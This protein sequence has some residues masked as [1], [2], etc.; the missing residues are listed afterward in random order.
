MPSSLLSKL[1]LSVFPGFGRTVSGKRHSISLLLRQGFSRKTGLPYSTYPLPYPMAASNS[2]P[3][4]GDVYVDDLITGCGNALD[5][6]K[7]TGVFFN[8]KSLISCRKAVVSLRRR[9]IS[10]SQISC[11]YFFAD[12]TRK[13]CNSNLLLGPQLRNLP[14][15]SLACYSARAAHDVSFDGNSRDEQ[16]PNAT[17]FSDQYVLLASVNL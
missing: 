3:V 9:E 14:S 5:F 7:P 17:N 6:A 13:N 8:D 15:S 4:F 12:V 11:G 10:N 16:N 1:N 2:K